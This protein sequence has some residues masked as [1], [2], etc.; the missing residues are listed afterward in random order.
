MGWI[1]RSG[2]HNCSLPKPTFKDIG[3]GYVCSDCGRKWTVTWKISILGLK[4]TPVFK[5]CEFQG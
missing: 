3:D 2:K 5:L 4:W 1:R